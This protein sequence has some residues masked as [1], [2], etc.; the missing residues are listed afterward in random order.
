[1]PLTIA[2]PTA[3]AC[4]E[5]R[6]IELRFIQRLR[7]IVGEDHPE[8]P[9][10][11]E[12]LNRA[13][14]TPAATSPTPERE[15]LERHLESAAAI[16]GRLAHDFGNMLT[17]ILGF[18]ELTLSQLPADSPSRRYVEETYQS[19]QQ[20]ARWVQR[21]QLFSR[22][23]RAAAIPGSLTAAVA[24]EEARV[25][26]I[27]GNAVALSVSLPNDLPGLA[28]DTG[29]LQQVLAEVLDNAREA[30][31][32]PGIVTVSA[33]RAELTAR[34]CG[35][36][37]G[38]VQP[39]S[40]VEVTVTDTGCGLTPDVRL[41]LFNDIFFSTKPRHRGLGLAVVYGLLRGHR[42]GICLGPNPEQGAAIRLFFPVAAEK[43]TRAG[44]SLGASSERH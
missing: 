9:K 40:Y 41:R 15:S 19:A 18:T 3:D 20:G 24:Q 13:Y 11:L 32:G 44:R 43:T 31:T 14:G 23:G 4:K 30:I 10:L 5:A 36:I 39:G 28:L 17:G 2:N 22:R 1:M 8:L 26:P 6:P 29:A 33:R 38:N 37:I 42:G 16:S 21:V 25:R 27:W 35:P 7:R 34:E 12:D